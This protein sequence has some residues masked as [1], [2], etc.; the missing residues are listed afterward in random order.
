MLHLNSSCISD[1]EHIERVLKRKDYEGIKTSAEIK[2]VFENLGEAFKTFSDSLKKIH[3]DGNAIISSIKKRHKEEGES[4]RVYLAD[5]FVNVVTLVHNLYE[6]NLSISEKIKNEIVLELEKEEDERVQEINSIYNEEEEGS[7]TL[8]GNRGGQSHEDEFS[9]AERWECQTGSAGPHDQGVHDKGMI[10]HDG[11]RD[12]LHKEDY[13]HDQEILVDGIPLRQIEIDLKRCLENEHFAKE[14]LNSA[15][16]KKHFAAL[17]KLN[18][19]LDKEIQAFKEI[20]DKFG[21]NANKHLI[22]KSKERINAIQIGKKKIF[23]ILYDNI[24]ELRHNKRSMRC[25]IKDLE[26]Y[27]QD[28]ECRW[29]KYQDKERKGAGRRESQNG[30][31]SKEEN[32]PHKLDEQKRQKKT[33]KGINLEKFEIRE[34][35]RIEKIYT[36]LRGFI[37]ILAVEHIHMNSVLHKGA[38]EIS[39]YDSL[40]DYQMWLSLVLRKNVDIAD[41]QQKI[42]QN[43]VLTEEEQ[44]R[45]MPHRGHS[46]AADMQHTSD[47]KRKTNEQ[48]FRSGE[49]ICTEKSSP[50]GEAERKKQKHLQRGTDRAPSPRDG[51][52]PE[53][54]Y[55]P[56]IIERSTYKS[57]ED[58]TPIEQEAR[59]T[60][61]TREVQ[62]N[63][64]L[65]Q[66]KDET[67][68]IAKQP[69][70][71]KD[72]D[73][74]SFLTNRQKECEKYMLQF[75]R[76]DIL[77]TMLSRRSKEKRKWY[78][79]HFFQSYFFEE[80]HPFYP[81]KIPPSIN[82]FSTF[83]KWSL[84]SSSTR[85]PLFDEE[86]QMSEYE[87]QLLAYESLLLVY[88]FLSTQLNGYFLFDM[89]KKD[90]LNKEVYN[91]FY[92][93][94]YPMLEIMQSGKKQ[95]D[96]HV[97][98]AKE[99]G[100]KKY[101]T[102]P[103]TNKRNTL[104]DH[105]KYVNHIYNVKLQNLLLVKRIASIFR[106]KLQLNSK[107]NDLIT[108]LTIPSHD[109]NWGHTYS[110][111]VLDVR[112]R[113]IRIMDSLN[114]NH[115]FHTDVENKRKKADP[116]GEAHANEESRIYTS[117]LRRQLQLLHIS[118][119]CKFYTFVKFVPFFD[120]H[121]DCYLKDAL[122]QFENDE[123][124][125]SYL[126]RGSGDNPFVSYLRNVQKRI[127]QLHW[128]VLHQRGVAHHHGETKK[129]LTPQHPKEGET[130]EKST[131]E[132]TNDNPNFITF[133][134]LRRDEQ[135]IFLCNLL[136]KNLIK[137]F[138]LI[139]FL[140]SL[141][142]ENKW[143]TGVC[144]EKRKLANL[145]KYFTKIEYY[146]YEVRKIAICHYVRGNVYPYQEKL[147]RKHSR[148]ESEGEPTGGVCSPMYDD[149]N[150][151]HDELYKNIFMKEL[152][153]WI[154]T[155]QSRSIR[156]TRSVHTTTPANETRLTPR[157][158]KIR[159]KIFY[160]LNVET[161]L[162]SSWFIDRSLLHF[163][164][165]YYI[166]CVI[167]T[168]EKTNMYADMPYLMQGIMLVVYYLQA[169]NDLAL[170]GKTKGFNDGVEPT[171][172]PIST[173][174]LYLGIHLFYSFF[175]KN[176]LTVCP[177]EENGK[178]K[179]F[180][181]THSGTLN[182]ENDSKWDQMEKY[183]LP[184]MSPAPRKSQIINVQNASQ[185][186]FLVKHFESILS[187]RTV[188]EMDMRNGEKETLHKNA[189]ADLEEAMEVLYGDD[190]CSHEDKQEPNQRAQFSKKKHPFCAN[191]PNNHH[192][193]ENANST[194][195]LLQKRKE[196]KKRQNE[197][198]YLKRY[199]NILLHFNYN[200][201]ENLISPYIPN[202]FSLYG[203]DELYSKD[204]FCFEWCVKNDGCVK[205]HAGG[206]EATKHV[207]L[208]ASRGGEE[209][210]KQVRFDA[211]EEGEC[212]REDSLQ[213]EGTGDHPNADNTRKTSTTAVHDKQN[214]LMRTNAEV[215]K[216]H[217]FDA[218]TNNTLVIRYRTHK[219]THANFSLI[220]LS[221]V[222][223]VMTDI[224]LMRMISC[225][226]RDH[227]ILLLCNYRKYIDMYSLPYVLDVFVMLQKFFTINDN[228]FEEKSN[229]L[230][231][232][233]GVHTNRMHHSRRRPNQQC[234]KTL[235]DRFCNVLV[236]DLNDKDLHCSRR[237]H[238]S[239]H[240]FTPDEVI[241]GNRTKHT[242][243]TH[244]I[245]SSEHQLSSFFKFF[246]FNTVKNIFFNIVC[247]VKEDIEASE[248]LQKGENG[249]SQSG[250]ELHQTSGGVAAGALPPAERHSPEEE[251][252]QEVDQD[253]EEE[254]GAS[255]S[256]SG[257]DDH[258]GSD[259]DLP[260]NFIAPLTK[261]YVDIINK[262]I[263]E[264]VAEIIFFS[265]IWKQYLSPEDHP[266]MVLFST[267][268]T[269]YYEVTKFIRINKNHKDV[270][271]SQALSIIVSLYNFNL[272]IKEIVL[273]TNMYEKYQCL[274][275]E[276]P[277]ADRVS[278]GVKRPSTGTTPTVSDNLPMG[279]SPS[280]DA[281]PVAE[282]ANRARSP[283]RK[284]Q[285]K[286]AQY[287]ETRNSMRGSCVEGQTR[288][289]KKTRDEK[290]EQTLRE[291]AHNRFINLSLII[292]NA[293]DP[294]MVKLMFKLEKLF[295]QI[296]DQKLEHNKNLLSV[297]LKNEE[298]IPLNSPDIMYNA[299]SVDIFSIIWRILDVLFEY[300]CPVEWIITPFVQFL[301]T[302]INDY[303]ENYKKKYTSFIISLMNQY[304]DKYFQE[305]LNLTEQ[306]KIQWDKFSSSNIIK[307]RNKKEG[308]K[309]EDEPG[310]SIFKHNQLDILD[311][312]EEEEQDDFVLYNENIQNEYNDMNEVTER[313]KHRKNKWKKNVLYKL[314][315][316]DDID[317]NAIKNKVGEFLEDIND[318]SV[319]VSPFQS[320]SPSKEAK[321]EPADAAVEEEAGLSGTHQLSPSNQANCEPP[322]EEKKPGAYMSDDLVNIIDEINHLFNNSDMSSSVVITW[323]LFFFQEQVALIRNKF[324]KY[325]LD[326]IATRTQNLDKLS[327]IFNNY[328]TFNITLPMLK[329]NMYTK[330]ILDILN[331]SISN[332]RDTLKNTIY[333]IFKVL[334][335]RIVCYEFQREIFFNLYEHPFDTN[336][337]QS[338]VDMFPNTVEKFILQIPESFRKSILT[339]FIELFIKMW[340]LVVVE[341]G[342]SSYLFSDNDIHLMKRD[343]QCIRKYMQQKGIH[344]SHWFLTKKYDLTEYIDT[345]FDLLYGDRH[346]FL[347][348][349]SEQKER[350][351]M[352]IMSSAY[353][354][355]MAIITGINQHIQENL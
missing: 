324:E 53:Q 41:L 200:H 34:K 337:V 108:L 85:V 214:S 196:E 329:K 51:Q 36:S 211:A 78:D 153:M 182:E 290:D 311:H 47:K 2:S 67:C 252:E 129:G 224:L 316:Y 256:E 4:D 135:I 50:G 320:S 110:F 179:L 48:N 188:N 139:Y 307:R 118:V 147:Q 338:I 219:K 305:L 24:K 332:I 241:K 265:N 269:L 221:R 170:K 143:N 11:K 255:R 199:C 45:L 226:F 22:N 8:N 142:K 97:E 239:C 133:K 353:N 240:I 328:L 242:H 61:K 259:A 172:I 40:I 321:G 325:I 186:C 310:G 306:Q 7:T 232:R 187:Y 250:P 127:K 88:Y 228:S 243:L 38:C 26:Q 69:P 119:Y 288:Q 58:T 66:K 5:C 194:E 184:S 301:N 272:V 146:D 193:L 117:W 230:K 302:F 59:G 154:P 68:L 102:P 174:I 349:I 205:V 91:E 128:F 342:F 70:M 231:Y 237:S 336:N 65:G 130:G 152:S 164:L 137:S 293:S 3:S 323:N 1:I 74:F 28:N 120:S 73:I 280:G 335:F 191:V 260:L 138:R 341:K 348:I 206:E 131:D 308:S 148:N 212:K 35:H 162:C 155:G 339:V 166:S 32:S 64:Y 46:P 216:G 156:S 18:I 55:I 287:Y 315:D 76:V 282:E 201:V 267:N 223:K 171:P 278:Q 81:F 160:K 318:L 344:L 54:Y 92:Q 94:C 327:H 313:I 17:D 71:E 80:G 227:F 253:K 116:T 63:T 298:L 352:N 244:G 126:G 42:P 176:V 86:E 62:V 60:R 254:D 319:K 31:F 331:T 245:I 261:H 213:A 185:F 304:A 12:G 295:I 276:K 225:D 350:K 300:K 15:K 37:K 19:K 72:Q 123:E 75:N 340:I 347:N 296:M 262:Y 248:L 125:F 168:S 283:R 25:S 268:R 44:F 275:N 161:I 354:K 101:T 251:K 284:M 106:I 314:F 173:F 83:E 114:F 107:S 98:A 165:Y 189:D 351:S 343:N 209:T 238:G 257:S 159:R 345:F 177:N 249:H 140:K 89:S 9:T 271:F 82:H 279:D 90:K 192:A 167:G 317:V 122:D 292:S 236:E 207:R 297:C 235:F 95:T 21:K 29:K 104:N 43:D 198:I 134:S 355:G 281:T 246:I 285:N 303:C 13:T 39:S 180:L 247:S 20:L 291:D 6:E 229:R 178:V 217:K 132:N 326:Y 215:E 181:R 333:Y 77:S 113:I 286:I 169:G 33:F 190:S 56:V 151:D 115:V 16:Y 273:Q 330:T 312:E 145:I 203:Q 210:T 208:D 158:E 197:L 163:F 258:P 234:G 105:L 109:T 202:V 103:T 144:D 111:H 10:I 220:N 136:L 183:Y 277:L 299:T 30:D 309:A 100:Y 14:Y 264:V 124:Y 233:H 195:N 49:L 263:N 289:Q 96:T 87:Y 294:C 121:S 346:L 222:E 84:T 270:L 334:S 52:F 150:V 93:R 274:V 322:R 23:E 175:D 141:V 157:E 112:F 204:H 218:S 149:Q 27:I 79:Q 99:E 266:L 57:E